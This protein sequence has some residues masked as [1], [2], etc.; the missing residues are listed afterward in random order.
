MPADF[1]L[2]PAKPQPDGVLV[3][4]LARAWRWQK[5]LDRGVYSSVTEIAEAERISKSYVEPNPA[6]GAAG[7]GR[8]RGD[9]WRLGGPAGDVG[10]VGAAAADSVGNDGLG[11]SSSVSTFSTNG[12]ITRLDRVTGTHTVNADCTGSSVYSD[13]TRYDN[14]IAPDGSTLVFVQTN[15]GTVAAGFEPRAMARRVDD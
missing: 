12:K 15:P 13:G 5:L 10:A 8:R 11:N 14:F 1:G 6:A 4:A 9:P 7:A 2:L 3:K